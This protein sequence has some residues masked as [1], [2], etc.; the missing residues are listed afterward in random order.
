M[1]ITAPRAKK[2]IYSS[3][4]HKLLKRFF[5]DSSVLSATTDIEFMST[6]MNACCMRDQIEA[7][8]E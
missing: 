3:T 6:H 4:P 5:L 2:N 7:L 8:V 1:Y